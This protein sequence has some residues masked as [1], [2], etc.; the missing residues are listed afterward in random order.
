MS[1]QKYVRKTEIVTLVGKSKTVW[2]NSKIIITAEFIF[3]QGFN[4]SIE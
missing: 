1:G 4:D 3:K 2:R